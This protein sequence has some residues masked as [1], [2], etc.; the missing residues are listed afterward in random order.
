MIHYAKK[1]PKIMPTKASRV[2]NKL[3]AWVW[4]YLQ[5]QD[6]KHAIAKERRQLAGLSEAML[7]DIGIDRM[8]AMQEAQR[9]DIPES[10]TAHFNL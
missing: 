5:T 7:K 4:C 3:L 8:Q 6:F 9:Q 10:R 1:D 2:A